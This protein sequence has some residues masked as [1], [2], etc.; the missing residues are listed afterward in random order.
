[1]GPEVEQESEL[2][3]GS[4]E[5]VI[6]LPRRCSVRLIGGFDLDHQFFID[7]HVETLA[8]DHYAFVNDWNEDLAANFVAAF[9]E[10]TL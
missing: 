9:A 7:Y 10:V 1:M 4:T 3:T 5:V 2:K 8:S 6:D